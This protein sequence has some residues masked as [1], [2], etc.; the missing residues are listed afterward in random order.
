MITEAQAWQRVIE[1]RKTVD[2]CRW[3]HERRVPRCDD[4][5]TKVALEQACRNLRLALAA[6][7]KFV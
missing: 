2:A 7:Q 1:A 5:P 3:M 6:W 4:V